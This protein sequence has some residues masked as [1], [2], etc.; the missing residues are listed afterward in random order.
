MFYMR[1]TT[2]MFLTQ[3]WSLELAPGSFYNF[4][5]MAI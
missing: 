1:N 4:I 2:N 3:S 5:K